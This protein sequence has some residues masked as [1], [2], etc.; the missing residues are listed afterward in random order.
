MSIDHAETK[1][2][3]K[4]IHR[5]ADLVDTALTNIEGKMKQNWKCASVDEK[6]FP[7]INKYVTPTRKMREDLQP[8][9]V[10]TV[11]SDYEYDEERKEISD[12]EEYSDDEDSEIEIN[13]N[14]LESF[15][16]TD[17]LIESE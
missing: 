14:T 16:E 12:N 17:Q 9:L 6:R 2:A 7:K 8:N 10:E 13:E 11:V 5:S 3:C 15:D 1:V 4:I